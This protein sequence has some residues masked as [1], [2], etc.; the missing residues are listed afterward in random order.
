[1]HADN[2]KATNPM[3]CAALKGVSSLFII[4]VIITV[5]SAQPMIGMKYL[6]F[7]CNAYL[8]LH[9]VSGNSKIGFIPC[10]E[11]Y[12][13]YRTKARTANTKTKVDR[14]NA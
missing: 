14:I 1:M 4:N 3:L 5:G 13:T 7:M 10:F 6:N 11:F 2:T 12:K 8:Y 9:M